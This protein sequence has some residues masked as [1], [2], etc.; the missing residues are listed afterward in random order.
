MRSCSE[1][2]ENAIEV[3]SVSKKFS[4]RSRDSV[5]GR[6]GAPSEVSIL[7]DV[8]FSVK[9]GEMLGIVGRNGIGKTTLL[10][11]IAGI[12]RPDSGE[13]RTS[14]SMVPLLSLGTGFN[15]ELSAKDNVVFYGKILGFAHGEIMGKVDEIIGFAELERFRDVK[16]KKFSTGMGMRLA[17][18][19]AVQIDPDIILVDEILAVGDPPFQK[20]SYD[21]FMRFKERKKTIVFVSHDLNSINSLCD[22]AILLEGGRIASQGDPSMVVNDYM[23]ML[24]GESREGR[25]GRP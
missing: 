23:G 12:Y 16:L 10:R 13:I 11:L 24:D 19:T 15:P 22:R 1:S 18:A 20:K 9:K 14:G 8:S 25:E 7:R 17:F 5:F 3:D 21:A 2:P 4:T 6:T